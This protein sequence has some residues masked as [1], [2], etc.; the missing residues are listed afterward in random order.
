MYNQN[1]Y[2]ESSAIIFTGFLTCEV[3][4]I[5]VGR[6]NWTLGHSER[7]KTMIDAHGI[8]WI[9]IFITRSS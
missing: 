2:P 9:Y 5:M 6:A 4:T 7:N 8:N 1:R 3:R